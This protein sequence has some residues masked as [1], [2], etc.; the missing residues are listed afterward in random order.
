M[1]KLPVLPQTPSAPPGDS[2]GHPARDDS[3]WS[4]LEGRAPTG[5]HAT[6]SVDELE[7]QLLEQTGLLHTT[8]SN[9]SQGIL[10]F[11]AERRVILYNA[12]ACHLLDLPPAFLA[13]KP[14][15]SILLQFQ[16]QRGDFG[17]EAALVGQS[18]REYILGGGHLHPPRR[19]L[20]TTPA[21][22]TL[23]V[24]TRMMSTGGMVRTIADITR[25]VQAQA[26]RQH[27]ERLSSE[28]QATAQVGAWD[29][30]FANDTVTWT[31]GI[32]RILELSTTDYVPSLEAMRCFFPPQSLERIAIACDDTQLQPGS[33]DLEL[34]MVT[35]KGNTIWVHMVGSTQWRFSLPMRRTA[36][37]QDITERKRSEATWREDIA[38]WKL[39]LESTGD[40]MWD[41][42]VRT[43][44]E[45]FSPNLLR[46]YGFVEK[47]IDQSIH[48]LDARTHPD[49]VPRMMRDR[50]AHLDG[51][52]PV[53]RNEH[54]VRCK[55]GSWKWVLS[56]GMVISRDELGRP[57][58][59]IGT[60]T[61]ITEHKAAEAQIWQQANF[62]TLTGLPNRRMLRSRLEQELKKCRRDGHKLTVA[63]V[64]LDHFKEVNDTLGHHHGDALLIQATQRILG[65]LRE[66]DTVARMG[67]DE[68]TLLLTEIVDT[69]HIETILAKLLCTLG[70]A[71]LLDQQ[72]V[73]VSASVGVT[74]Y[75]DDAT[76]IEDLFRN[77]D[78]ALYAAKDAGRNRFCYFTPELQHAAQ[79][80]VRLTND[81]R[82]ALAVEQ[83]Q[84]VY[85]PIVELATGHIHKAEALL[86]WEHPQRGSVSPGEFIP[87]AESSGLIVE[88]GEWV[89][90]RALEQVCR[91]RQRLHPQFQV[92]VNKSPVQFEKVDLARSRWIDQ[93]RQ[94]GQE[95]NCLVV[96]I[97]EGLLLSHSDEVIEQILAL[98]DDGIQVSLDDFGTGY[99]SLA[100]L[101][102]FDI[103]YIK[104]DQ[105]FV[106][107]L[108]GESTDLALCQAIIAM[109]HALNMQVIAEGVETAQQRDLLAAAGCDYGQGYLFSRPVRSEEL[110]ALVL[111][112]NRGVTPMRV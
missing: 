81:L 92:S 33:F 57:L 90:Q 44:Q 27:L 16:L 7:K 69:R 25:Y 48:A 19:F 26:D 54:R 75:P 2:H 29:M 58:R 50:Q 31:E 36:I 49:D 53:Y 79:R 13:T 110:E 63:F 106:R 104:I 100:Y 99:S 98:S 96:E 11:D 39:A 103:D 24:R 97:T 64:D 9:I 89:F 23:E 86:R 60:H 6:F 43:G 82:A 40:G 45:Y 34:E 72:Q 56:R 62:D 3:D 59:M 52:T 84:V 95:G 107:Q 12:Q 17:P 85:Q 47:D 32:Y 10:V 8:L 109:A 112:T 61:D 14:T 71:F 76:A 67:G 41:L 42:D 105:S 51:R 5:L 38:R 28:M 18:A 108:V 111:R 22:R 87:I 37:V 21:G 83:F 91:W 35:A 94:H 77:A 70:E 4:T 68:F 65:C 1:A 102:K 66:V 15:L 20:R 74:I 88:I 30:D 73:Y 78:Q 101:Q 80:R 55:S 93:I 46:M